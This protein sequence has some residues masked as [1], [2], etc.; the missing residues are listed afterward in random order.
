MAI[1]DLL[2]I[3]RSS[4][5]A[6][7]RALTTTGNNVAN[8]NTPGFSRQRTVLDSVAAG[9]GSGV[10][11]AGVE[12]IVDELLEGRA[13][14]QA[15]S[16][17]E[18]EARRELL[19]V[20]EGNL[21]IGTASIGSALSELFAAASALSTHPAEIGV[22]SD[23]LARA[24][25]VAARIRSAAGGIASLQREADERAAGAVPE[26][27][28]LLDRVAALNATIARA[29]A[30]G[31][32]ANELRD[33]RRGALDEL[34][35][36]I[37][38]RTVAREDGS[39][40]VLARSGIALVTGTNAARLEARP[41]SA[42]GVD[43]RSLHEIGMVAPDGSLI[44]L[45]DD[46]GG[47]LGA[48]LALRDGTLATLSAD[49]DLLAT[50]LRD[51]VNAVQTD[52]A[53]R[54]LDGVVG[55]ALFAGTGALDL[56]VA[57]TDP[58]GIAAAQSSST[59]DNANALALVALQKTS[60]AAL[61]GATF[62]DYFGS[63]QARIGGLAREAEEQVTVERTLADAVAAQRENVS[64]VSL[65]EEFTD[66]IRFERGFQAAAQLIAVADRLLD[67][68]LVLRR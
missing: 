53:G 26:V 16:L 57:L 50:T 30:L 13:L 66:L 43:G 22:R 14:L 5:L 54:D 27:N 12:Q 59:G 3:G 21:P 65:E 61:D 33:Q 28:R 2:S 35:R 23:F 38:V 8:V 51:E 63:L 44:P 47:E 19:D 39:V 40:D 32:N 9:N 6:H 52:P 68:L 60:V 45:G 4:L 36:V 25:T 11:V 34:A 64:G 17:G 48:H 29:Q 41:G 18:A 10:R 58:R 67:E 46:P 55:T 24:E 1:L 56:E 15:T 37:G 49:L 62:N 20:A 31:E 42:T 7:Q